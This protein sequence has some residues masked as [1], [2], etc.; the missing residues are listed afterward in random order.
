VSRFRCESA[1]A[2][3]DHN[4]ATCFSSRARVLISYPD[5]FRGRIET[6]V[7]PEGAWY[8]L[9]DQA[10]EAWGHGL[11]G[12]MDRAEVMGLCPNGLLDRFAAP[13]VDGAQG[14]LAIE[15]M[16]ETYSTVPFPGTLLEQPNALLE[17]FAVVRSTRN[18]IQARRMKAEAEKHTGTSGRR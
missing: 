9:S 17:A 12:M 8:H 1:R 3:G 2:R 16:C 6:A 4:D 15:S 7:G 5:P 11:V 18:E 13:E 14:V 10:H